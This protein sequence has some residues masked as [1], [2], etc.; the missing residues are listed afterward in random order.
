MHAVGNTPGV[1][2]LDDTLLFGGVLA[3][4]FPLSSVCEYGECCNNAIDEAT[5]AA[6]FG[7][8]SKEARVGLSLPADS[9]LPELCTT[10]FTFSQHYCHTICS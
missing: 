3:L 5:I 2:G 10:L 6:L 7:D 9:D 8:P 1:S 4:Y